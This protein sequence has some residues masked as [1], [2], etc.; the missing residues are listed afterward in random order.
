M[1]VPNS[2]KADK[3]SGFICDHSIEWCNTRCTLGLKLLFSSGGKKNY[4]VLL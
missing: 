2:S 4:I 1:M 3:A